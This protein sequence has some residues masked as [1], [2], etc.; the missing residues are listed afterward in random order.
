VDAPALIARLQV[1]P[2]VLPGLLTGLSAA[3]ARIKPPSGAWSILEIVNHLVDEEIEDFRQRLELTLRDPALPW[4]KNNPEAWA[5]D[6]RYNEQDLAAS[7]Q[8]FLTERHKSLAWLRSLKTPDWS[9]AHQHPQGALT[10][11]DLLASWTAH[12]QLHIRQLAKRL[13][14]LTTR[15][16]KPHSTDY[17]GPWGA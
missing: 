12:D 2:A 17:A 16:A 11:G 9:K 3:D 1:L 8:R 4:P 10:A 15:D 14:E 13:Y 5:T 7:V 6:R